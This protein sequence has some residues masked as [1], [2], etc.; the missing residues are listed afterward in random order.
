MIGLGRA[1]PFAERVEVA[2]AEP[3]FFGPVFRIGEAVL[4]FGIE[5]HALVLMEGPAGARLG[6]QLFPLF[7]V[8][9]LR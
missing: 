3:H 9:P 8:C 1:P 7:G 4:A 6:N 2:A 5:R